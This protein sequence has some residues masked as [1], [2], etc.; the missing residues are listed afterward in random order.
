MFL[1]NRF[2]IRRK[3]CRRQQSDGVQYVKNLA[4]NHQKQ[5]INDTAYHQENMQLGDV[6][7]KLHGGQD[8]ERHYSKKLLKI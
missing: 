2:R 3:T 7:H 6:V 4:I 8:V 5:K 1:S